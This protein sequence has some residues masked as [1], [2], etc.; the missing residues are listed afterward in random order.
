MNKGLT[1][2]TTSKKIVNL[3][4]VF[5]L[6]KYLSNFLLIIKA[7]TSNSIKALNSKI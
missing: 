6:K 3:Y 5:Q 4:L 1:L 7:N 2:I